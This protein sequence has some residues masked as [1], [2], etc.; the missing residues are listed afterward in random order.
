MNIIRGDNAITRTIRLALFAL[1][2][3][4]VAE[5]LGTTIHEVL[6][7]GLTALLIGGQFSGFTVKWDTMG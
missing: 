4:Y 2:L 6:G 1:P 5:V 7:H 3:I